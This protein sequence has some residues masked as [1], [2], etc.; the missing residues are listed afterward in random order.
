MGLPPN[1]EDRLRVEKIF[2]LEEKE[3]HVNVERSDPA[4]RHLT[5]PP[6]IE[7]W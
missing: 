5:V 6:K 7:P 1:S 4:E 2:K 3:N